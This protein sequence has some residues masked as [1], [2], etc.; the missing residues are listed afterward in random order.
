MDQSICKIT[1]KK[2]TQI[3][4]ISFVSPNLQLHVWKK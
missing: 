3:N 2:E 1:A 4:F